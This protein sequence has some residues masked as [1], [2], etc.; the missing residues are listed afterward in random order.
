MIAAEEVDC[1][2]EFY[3]E[4]EDQGEDLDWETATV[5][6]VSEKEVFGGFEWSSGVIVYEF[7]EVI[8]LSVDV[9]DDGDGILYLDH[10][11]LD[12]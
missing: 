8:E 3:F 9:S 6:V 12:L 11:G 1:V 2:L 5:D 7:D 4:G 10:V